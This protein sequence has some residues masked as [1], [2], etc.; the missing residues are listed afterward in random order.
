[1]FLFTV[2]GVEGIKYL[3]FKIHGYKIYDSSEYCSKDVNVSLY[4]LCSMGSEVVVLLLIG[5]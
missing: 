1:M 4:F 5:V 2:F 3:C